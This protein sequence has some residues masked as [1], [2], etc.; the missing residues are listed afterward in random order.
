MRRIVINSTINLWERVISDIERRKPL[1]PKQQLTENLIKSTLSYLKEYRGML[2]RTDPS[3]AAVNPAKVE[4]TEISTEHCE[5]ITLS[6]LF[7]GNG[8]YI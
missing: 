7:G 4:T 8:Y 5:V 2:E 3:I 1:R 6:D